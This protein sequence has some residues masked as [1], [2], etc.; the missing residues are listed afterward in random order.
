MRPSIAHDD[1]VTRL[2][3]TTVDVRVVSKE[4]L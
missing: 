2:A 3:E 4:S 1:F